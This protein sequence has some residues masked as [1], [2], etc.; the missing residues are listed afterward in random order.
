MTFALVVA[1]RNINDVVLNRYMK[2]ITKDI[3]IINRCGLHARPS[4]A[5]SKTARQFKSDV[6]VE[7]KDMKVS[8]RSIMGLMTLE[9]GFGSIIRVT[10]T[11]DDAEEL[12]KV[13]EDL[14]LTKFSED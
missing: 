6:F 7:L 5:F 3:T 13:L 9:A 10:A 4:A 11:G 8:G 12:V 1:E 2:T 14:V